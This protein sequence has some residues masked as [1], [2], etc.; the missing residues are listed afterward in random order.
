MIRRNNARGRATAKYKKRAVITRG[1]ALP[2]SLFMRA[3]RSKQGEGRVTPPT[4]DVIV[5]RG[6][7]P[8]R[9]T[10]S[11]ADDERVVISVAAR[12]GELQRESGKRG[13]V[14]T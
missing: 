8:S 1:L 7:V 14:H 4:D 11:G 5:A 9:S 10:H 6:T 3:R 12:Q 13:R 2:S